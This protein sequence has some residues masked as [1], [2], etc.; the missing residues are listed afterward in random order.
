[1]TWLYTPSTYA[2]GTEDSSWPSASP[3]KLL[4]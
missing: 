1:M 2:A 3:D 4:A